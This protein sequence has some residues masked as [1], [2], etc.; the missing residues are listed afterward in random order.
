MAEYRLTE[1]FPLTANLNNTTDTTY[2]NT[3]YRYHDVT[4][5]GRVLQ[6]NMTARY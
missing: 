3:H 6:V 4:S 5:K 2:A 1:T